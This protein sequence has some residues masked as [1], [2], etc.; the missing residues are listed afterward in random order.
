MYLKRNFYEWW[1]IGIYDGN[2]W[3]YGR[4]NVYVIYFYCWSIWVL[5]FGRVCYGVFKFYGCLGLWYFD[6]CGWRN[7]SLLG[8]LKIGW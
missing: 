7:L 2:G 6:E 5:G 1:Y 4:W 3:K 8:L